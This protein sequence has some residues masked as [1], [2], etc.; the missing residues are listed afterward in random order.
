MT[1][2]LTSPNNTTIKLCT[3]MCD[4]VSSLHRL[5]V[6]VVVVVVVVIVIDII[7]IV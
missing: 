2:K 5:V 4:R 1:E 3:N 6:V 7:I